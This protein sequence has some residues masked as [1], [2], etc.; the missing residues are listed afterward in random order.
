MGC[1]K[2]LPETAPVKGTVKYQGKLVP[3]G[4]IMFQPPS[5]P[6]A[7]ANIQQGQYVLRTFR[8]GDGAILGPHKVTIIS[9]ED[10]SGLLPE[11]RNPLP[12][13]IIPMKYSFPDQSNL[14]AIVE[15]K[16]NV[17]DFDLK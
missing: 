13:A 4:S 3:Q 7:T 5:G 14:T 10:Q 6:P 15:K 2:N 11:N 1:G 17:I 9:L 16:Q 12:P 8:D